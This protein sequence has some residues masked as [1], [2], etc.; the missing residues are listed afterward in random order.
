MPLRLPLGTLQLGL[1]EFGSGGDGR[2]PILKR[3][4][5]SQVVPRERGVEGWLW[6]SAAA[7]L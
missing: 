5:A 6:T 1:V 7:R 3:L 2:F 4:S